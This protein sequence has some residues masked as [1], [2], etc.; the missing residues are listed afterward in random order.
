MADTAEKHAYYY[1]ANR[2]KKEPLNTISTYATRCHHQIGIG[3]AKG[4]RSI[5]ASLDISGAYNNVPHKRLLYILRAK[6]SQN[7]LYNLF[8]GLQVR[9]RHYWSSGI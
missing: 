1:K 4:L 5:N 2:G 8:K 7:G 3:D 9:K 6:A